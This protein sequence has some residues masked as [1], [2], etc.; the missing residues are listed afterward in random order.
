MKLVGKAL[1]VCSQYY[2]GETMLHASRVANYVLSNPLVRDNLEELCLIVALLHDVVEDT[3]YTLEQ[4]KEDF[5]LK[6]FTWFGKDPGILIA[7]TVDIVTKR[8]NEKYTDYIIRVKEAA[9]SNNIEGEAAYWVKVADMKDHL[10]LTDT[11]TDKRKEKY[12]AGLA[13]LL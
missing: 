10:S 11:L 4:L 3:D 5:S 7:N 9:I 2:D 6:S 8:E 12:L 13:I 1:E